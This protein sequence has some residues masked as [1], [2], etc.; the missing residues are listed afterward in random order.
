MG[1][2]SVAR[3]RKIAGLV[4]WIVTLFAIAVMV[5]RDSTAQETLPPNAVAYN[6]RGLAYSKKGDTDR[7]IADYTQAVQLDPKYAHAYQNRGLAY[8]GKGDTDRAI[9]DSRRARQLDPLGN[10]GRTPFPTQRL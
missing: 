6:N 1:A 7:A 5:S 2:C 9:A 8:Y 10:R 4:A 3:L